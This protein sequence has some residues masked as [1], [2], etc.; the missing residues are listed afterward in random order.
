MTPQMI[1]RKG[2]IEARHKYSSQLKILRFVRQFSWRNFFALYSGS[3]QNFALV[4]SNMFINAPEDNCK[5]DVLSDQQKGVRIYFGASVLSFFPLPGDFLSI[6]AMLISTTHTLWAKSIRP[7]AGVKIRRIIFDYFLLSITQPSSKVPNAK[8]Q[9][10][11]IKY[12]VQNTTALVED[13]RRTGSICDRSFM[14]DA[15][16]CE[17]TCTTVRADEHSSINNLG[18]RPSFF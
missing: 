16:M 13:S 2:C 1:P 11:N 17:Y 8:Y 12:Q 6:S 14:C 10:L 7:C 18:P 5:A 3:S 9:V 15:E 4:T